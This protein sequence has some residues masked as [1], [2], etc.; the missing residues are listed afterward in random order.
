MRWTAHSFLSRIAGPSE[1]R[2]IFG[3]AWG[4]AIADEAIAL[5][6]AA[7]LDPSAWDAHLPLLH[8]EY[9]AWRFAPG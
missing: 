6:A 7:R 5:D 4:F 8:A 1:V 2:A 3:F 9:A